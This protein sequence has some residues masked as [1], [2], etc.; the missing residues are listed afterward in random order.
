MEIDDLQ[1]KHAV[2]AL[3]SSDSSL[4]KA[5]QALAKKD[6]Q[7]FNLEKAL[8]EANDNI[9]ESREE[10]RKTIEAHQSRIKHLQEKYL[11]DV[12]RV[13][14]N[15]SALVNEKMEKELKEKHASQLQRTKEQHNIETE[16]I[17]A[18][19]ENELKSLKNEA[20]KSHDEIRA[21]VELKWEARLN[22]CELEL[23]NVKVNR[24]E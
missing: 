23:D 13:S 2:E 9:Q 15:Q 11:Q 5:H 20:L 19:F 14:Q 22:D 17:K 10:R 8:K 18:C 3:Q 24:C 21:N 6:A 7:M 16:D 12:E 1:R 4:Q